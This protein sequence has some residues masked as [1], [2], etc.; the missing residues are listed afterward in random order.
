MKL[1]DVARLLLGRG[2][3]GV[4]MVGQVLDALGPGAEPP[5]SELERILFAVLRAG[6]FP[7]PLGQGRR[8]CDVREED[9]Y[10]LALV[11]TRSAKTGTTRIAKNCVRRIR[12][13][14]SSTAPHGMPV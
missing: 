3:D 5:A 12:L 8:P 1:E 14:A 4:A 10:R 2:R 13:A 7:P 11:A 9:G 6:G